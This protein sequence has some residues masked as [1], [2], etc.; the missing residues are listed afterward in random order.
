VFEG[1]PLWNIFGPNREVG[2]LTDLR[3]EHIYYDVYSPP[4]IISEAKSRKVK[5][6]GKSE[7]DSVVVL[8][9]DGRLL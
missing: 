1:R 9:I 6:A 8:R 3:N 7:G 2:D 4:S 5:W